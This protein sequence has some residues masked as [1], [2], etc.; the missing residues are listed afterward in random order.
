MQYLILCK[1]PWVPSFLCK[2]MVLLFLLLLPKPLM[3]CF[4]KTSQRVFDVVR[5]GSLMETIRW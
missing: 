1:F 4:C 2:L 3:F 5:L